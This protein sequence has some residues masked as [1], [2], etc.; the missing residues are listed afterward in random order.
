MPEYI[1]LLHEDPSQYA[2]MSPAD[3]QAIIEKYKLWSDT[4]GAKGQLLGGHKLADSGRRISMRAG[5]IAVTDGPYAETKEVI[6][7]FFHIR[8]ASYDEAV[9]ISKTC[10]HVANGVVEVRE[11]DAV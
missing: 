7:G 5:A 3:M 1:L 9:E 11:I 8:A 6:G 4:T 10:P 2:A